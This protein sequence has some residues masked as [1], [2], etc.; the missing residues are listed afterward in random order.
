MGKPFF[1][2]SW[3]QVGIVSIFAI[4][5][6]FLKSDIKDSPIVMLVCY[7]FLIV[8]LILRKGFDMWIAFLDERKKVRDDKLGSD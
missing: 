2:L 3:W 8:V 5:I 1:A 4:V 7:G 6:N